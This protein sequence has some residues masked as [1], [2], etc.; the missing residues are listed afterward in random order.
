MKQLICIVCRRGCFLSVDEE[1]GYA[2]TGN[3]CPRGAVYGKQELTNPT[4]V[5]TSTVKIK[6][7]L[8][9]RCPVK[10]DRA[11]PKKLLLSA[12]KQLNQIELKSPVHCGDVVIKDFLKTGANLVATKS[13]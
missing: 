13:M 11:I 1:N 10:T 6:N 12:M 7:A 5:V 9:R 4:R 3:A 2:V 8:H